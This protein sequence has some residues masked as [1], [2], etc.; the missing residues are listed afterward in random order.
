M[1]AHYT[2]N[3]YSYKTSVAIMVYLVLLSQ[4]QL[5]LPAHTHNLLNTYSSERVS[6]YLDILYK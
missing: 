5:S 4:L 6:T 2:H 3:N 1:Q